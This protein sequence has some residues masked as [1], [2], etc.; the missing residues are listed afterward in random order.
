MIQVKDIEALQEWERVTI[1]CDP[2]PICALETGQGNQPPWKWGKEGWG[3][4]KRVK[5]R[6]FSISHRAIT[7]SKRGMAP[8]FIETSGLV[9][10][11]I[12]DK[13]KLLQCTKFYAEEMVQEARQGYA[14]E[15]PWMLRC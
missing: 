6:R 5:M 1:N 15:T 10:K 7:M 11:S 2:V 9:G 14:Q 4:R 3:A 13:I 8:V 12:T